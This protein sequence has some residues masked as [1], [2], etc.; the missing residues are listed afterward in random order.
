[1]TMSRM[2]EDNERTILADVRRTYNEESYFS[3][4]DV[5]QLQTKLLTYYS[6]QKSID[7]K[8]GLHEVIAI[9]LYLFKDVIKDQ[10]ISSQIYPLF[11]N[12]IIKFIPFMNYE[13]DGLSIQM[14]QKYIRLLLLYHDPELCN[15][16]DQYDIMPEYYCYEWILLLFC[17]CNKIEN[18]LK[19]WDFYVVY[20]YYYEIGKWN[21]M[22]SYL[23]NCCTFNAK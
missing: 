8:Q 18:V 17:H 7:Y 19:L 15:H 20:Y 10:N 3:D 14:L 1:M 16:L 12:F 23:C 5:Q 9:F 21:K 6:V 13:D 2:D 11:Y 4:K 22:L